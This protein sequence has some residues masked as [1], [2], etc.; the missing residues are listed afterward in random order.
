MVD[1]G[2]IVTVDVISFRTLGLV[3][4]IHMI[5]DVVLLTAVWVVAVYEFRL[6]VHWFTRSLSFVSRMRKVWEVSF[7]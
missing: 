6:V 1:W 7:E 5:G 2:H 3:A 4:L